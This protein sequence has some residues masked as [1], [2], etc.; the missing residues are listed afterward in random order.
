MCSVSGVISKNNEDVFNHLMELLF[1]LKHRGNAFFGVSV[2][3]KTIHSKT[4]FSLRNNFIKGSIGLAHSLRPVR[5][6]HVQPID[7]SDGTIIFN[8][9]IYNFFEFSDSESDSLFIKEFFERE[10]KN[11]SI[12]K[13]VNKFMN[14]A[15]GEYSI[16]IYFKKKIY[17]FRD[18]FGIK[19]VWF[20]ENDSFIA[21]SSEPK[22]LKKMNINYPLPLLPG[23]LLILSQKGIEIKKVFSFDEM[24][25]KCIKKASFL[26]LKK[27]F[28][29]SVFLRTRNTDKAAVLFSGG[30]DSTVI[31]KAVSSMI[32]E[33]ELFSVGMQDSHDLNSAARASDELGL[34]LHTRV[35]E[36]DELKDLSLKCLSLLSFFDEMQLHLAVPE[37]AVCELVKKKGFS[38]IFS[39]QGSDEIFGGYHS[40]TKFS[41]NKVQNE[42]WHSIFNLWS[43]NLYREDLIS[44]NFYLE[45]RIPFLDK[46]LICTSMRIPVN[47]KIFSSKD[48]LRKRVLRKLALDLGISEEIALKP[49]K[50]L[51]YGSGVSKHISKFF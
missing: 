2:Q 34:K 29:E 26:D 51:Q 16:A 19:P 39:G 13:A 35:L 23:N 15:N 31:A 6:F 44:M 27:S 28:F 49:K 50:A 4:I 41:L 38:T 7:F 21:F 30:V 25:K 22:P 40:Y 36:K 10:L 37:Y 43:R 42:I 18:L 32:P 47:Q 45:H 48:N 9:E 24:K 1:D 3:G 17:V 8:G 11:N 12:E 14:N 46:D 33:T 5:G 20:G